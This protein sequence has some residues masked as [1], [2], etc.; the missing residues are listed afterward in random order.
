MDIEPL[1][2]TSRII[3]AV[4]VRSMASVDAD[5]T[6]PQLRVLVVLAAHDGT[7]MS[8]VAEELGVNPSNASRTCEQLVQR[9][10]VNRRAVSGDRRRVALTLAAPGR[11]LLERVMEHRRRL[12]EDVLARMAPQDQR[13]VVTAAA[14]FNAAAQKLSQSDAGDLEG[15]SAL[16]PWLG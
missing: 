13:A 8:G 5:L 10:L 15:S 3:N 12:L 16:A 4:I 11:G 9:G 7:S 6:V 2:A 14:R 1:M